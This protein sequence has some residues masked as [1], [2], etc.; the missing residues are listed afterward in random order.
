MAKAERELMKL[1][2]RYGRH[3]ENRGKHPAL[4]CDRGE[5]PP[6]FCSK[7]ASD[8]RALKNIE[9]DLK[10]AERNKQC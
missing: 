10:H 3:V 8:V 5:R 9:R 6:V 2:R 7:T 4:V 1:A